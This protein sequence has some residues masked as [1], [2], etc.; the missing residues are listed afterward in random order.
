MN[1]VVDKIGGVTTAKRHLFRYPV[2]GSANFRMR[3]IALMSSICSTEE[4]RKNA[5][6]KSA[7]L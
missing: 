5:I 7:I 4:Q 1:E 2:Y 6:I 3:K